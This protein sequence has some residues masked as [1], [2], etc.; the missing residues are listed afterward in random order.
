M[1]RRLS[2]AGLKGSISARKPL[3]RVSNKTKRLTL[4]KEHRNLWVED[5]GKVLWTDESKFEICGF[6][7]RCYMC[8][9][10]ADDEGIEF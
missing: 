10:N 7:R 3:L 5:W 8:C 1:C 2:K 6:S 4:A 9:R